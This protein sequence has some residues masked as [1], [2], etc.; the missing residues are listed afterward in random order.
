LKD[1]HFLIYF[2]AMKRISCCI[3]DMDGTLTRTNELIFATFNH[4]AGRYVGRTYTP[5]EIIKMFG[6]PEEIAVQRIVT[7]SQYTA[8]MDDFI[9]FYSDNHNVLATLHEG[10]P[11][12]LAYLHDRGV[13]LAVFT[14]KGRTTTLITLEK[15]GIKKYFDMIVSGSDVKKHKPSGEGIT[16]VIR[17]FGLPPEEVLMVGDAV[18]DVRAAQEAGVPVAAVLWDSYGIEHLRSMELKYMFHDV[19]ELFGWIRTKIPVDGARTH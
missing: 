6:P 1:P 14:G 15:F 10:I 19:A 18:A 12:L 17:A 5:D 8:A 11:E 2:E 13:L 4:I 9:T 16:N 7:P 3:F